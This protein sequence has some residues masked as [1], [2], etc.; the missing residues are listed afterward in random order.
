M[1]RS[2]QNSLI[3]PDLPRRHF[4]QG[5]AAGG[6]LLSLSP[7]LRSARAQEARGI[8]LGT[9]AVPGGT[10]LDLTIAETPVNCTCAPRIA[11]T[12]NGSIRGP[13]CAGA[14]AIR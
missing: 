12:V 14:R 11:T 6:V 9:V 13:S 2:C 7:W 3:L 5:V 4:L 10:E 8:L 1:T